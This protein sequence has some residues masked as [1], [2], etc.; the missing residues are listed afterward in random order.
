[1][2]ANLN[3]V[4]SPLPKILG[5]GSSQIL[6]RQICDLGRA[7]FQALEEEKFPDGEI[8]LRAVGNVAGE[9]IW[10][11]HS[12][13]FEPS[14]SPSD[15]IWELLLLISL[16]KDEG[17]KSVTALLPYFSYSRSD[18]KK[19]TQDPL[20]LRYLAQ[21]YEAAGMQKIFTMDVHNL[22]AFQ[23]AFRCPSI[24]L[25]AS[26]LFCDYLSEQSLPE[27]PLVVMSPD[28]GGL[29]RAEKFSKNLQA[30]LSKSQ[31]RPI[32]MAIVEKYREKEGLRGET[33]V[34]TVK[35][36]HVFMYD[37]IISTGKTVLRAAGLARKHGARSVTVMATHGLF[38]EEAEKT[39]TSPLIDE[40]VV[41][42]SNLSLLTP[43]F[44]EFPKLKIIS[45]APVLA[46]GLELMLTS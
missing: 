14:R 42:N 19:E 9:N 6:A 2:L 38:S 16:L 13:A 40:F 22:A 27:I 24:N 20:T 43:K 25:E 29:K 44:K 23:N 34:G 30:A 11:L 39:L 21:L 8:K 1:M 36:A 45:C 4:Q 5:I 46:Q 41:T 31:P 7:Q 28:L 37:D 15:K 18:Q 10:V 12:M 35:D 32:S 26:S 3:N 17:A 33:L